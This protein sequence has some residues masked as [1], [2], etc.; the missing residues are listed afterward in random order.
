MK[1]YERNST[2]ALQWN[3]IGES[4]LMRARLFSVKLIG[5]YMRTHQQIP[6]GFAEFDS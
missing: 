2:T 5:R 1:G 6:L 4:E 3:F